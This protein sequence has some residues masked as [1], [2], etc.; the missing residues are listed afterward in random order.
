MESRDYL[1]S[2]SNTSFIYVN[3]FVLLC[4]EGLFFRVLYNLWGYSFKPLLYLPEIIFCRLSPIWCILGNSFF[5]K[6]VSIAWL[7]L[8]GFLRKVNKDNF[9]RG[10]CVYF[11]RYTEVR[12]GLFNRL[13]VYNLP[14]IKN[15][16][17][18]KTIIINNNKLF[19]L[20]LNANAHYFEN[21]LLAEQ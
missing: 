3:K 8:S 18:N 21:A 10:W 1:Y 15:T 16:K 6:H 14:L 19:Q 12:K 9:E 20:T 5:K 4:K 2:E 17:Q 11:G 13:D 7:V